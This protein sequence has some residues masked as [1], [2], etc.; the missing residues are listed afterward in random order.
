MAAASFLQSP[1]VYPSRA[2]L[3]GTDALNR[4][5]R[6]F[7][8]RKA[9]IGTPGSLVRCP[10]KKSADGPRGCP[11]VARAGKRHHFHHEPK[12]PDVTDPSMNEWSPTLSMMI[13][14]DLCE[15]Y[16]EVTPAADTVIAEVMTKDVRSTSPDVPLE[17][18][19]EVFDEISGMPV[20]E[21][22][23]P[24]GIISHTDALKAN[25]QGTVREHMSSPIVVTKPS[26]TV[27]EAAKMMLEKKVTRLPVVDKQ[28]KIIGI[29]SRSDLFEVLCETKE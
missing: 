19:R 14:E 4:P 7:A 12:T 9:A 28:G 22:G 16:Y 24:V 26:S 6:P 8:H 29:V 2:A 17:S 11:V 3:A 23:K 21:D 15:H 10:G 1:C 13:Y 5:P 20:M 27:A 18:L 25:M